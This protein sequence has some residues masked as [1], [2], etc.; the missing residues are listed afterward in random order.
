MAAPVRFCVDPDWPPYEIISRSGAHEGIAADLLKLAAD[1]AGLTLTLFPTKDWDESIAASRRGDCDLLSFLNQTPRRDEWLVFTAP[2]F[3]DP[4]VII[5]HE[6]HA[7]VADLAAESEKTIVLPSGTSIEERVRR[8]FPNLRV[9]ITDSEAEAFAMVSNGRADLTIRSLTVAVYTIKKEGWFNLKVSGQVPGYEN[10]LRIGIVRERADLRD[11]LNQ[12][13]ATITPQERNQI[14]NRHVSIN[15]QT[16]IDY[17]MIRNLVLVFTVVLLSNLAWAMKLR[18]ANA[19][20]H[21]LSRTDRLT[22]LLNRTALDE[23]LL[24]QIGRARRHHHGF[25][26]IIIDL[27]HFKDV[28]DRLGH[29]TGDRILADLAGVLRE[30]GGNPER[31]GRWGGEEFLVLCP[32]TTTAQALALAE[33]ICDAVRSHAFETGWRHTV[34]AGVATLRPDDT[35]DGLIQRADAA[36]YRAKN[37]GRDR[38]CGAPDGQAA[39]A[40]G[41]GSPQPQITS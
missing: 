3:I 7:F 10:R 21:R 39:E 36:L 1:R 18:K 38:A 12:A 30:A 4:N 17:G 41:S 24:G 35:I 29:L 33:Q 13:I 9:I 28:N 27:D 14:A 19:Q 40:A 22:G 31:V 15:V 2:L 6:Q 25:A 32:E 5:T 34:S 23:L 8:D 11:L 37:E 20:L 26:M 16:A